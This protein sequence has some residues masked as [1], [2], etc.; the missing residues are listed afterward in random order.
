V[1][2]AIGAALQEAALRS[3]PHGARAPCVCRAA[4]RDAQAEREEA[5][6]RAADPRRAHGRRD[7]KVQTYSGGMKRRLDLALALS[8]LSRGSSSS[9]SRR[10][11]RSQSAARSDG[12]RRL[13]KE[14]WRHGFSDDAVPQEADVLADRVGII[15]TAARRRGNPDA[16]TG[17]N[18]PADGRGDSGD[19]AQLG[20]V[21]AVLERFGEPMPA[22]PGPIRRD[23]ERQGRSHGCPARARR[24]GPARGRLAPA[25]AVARRRLPREDRAQAR[26][27]RARSRV[28]LA[29]Q[30]IG[31]IAWRSSAARCGSPRRDRAAHVSHPAPG[32]QLKRPARGDAPARLPDT[33]VRLLLSPLRVI[34][35]GLFAA[36]RRA[37]TLRATSIPAFQPPALTPLRGTGCLPASS[38]ARWHR[39]SRRRWSTSASDWRSAC[40]SSARAG[41]VVLVLLALTIGAAWGSVG[42]LDRPAHRLGRSGAVAVSDPL[43]LHHHL[44]D[45]PASEP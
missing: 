20:S 35:G 2:A 40:T 32:H 27:R 6:R 28:N 31:L 18:R 30:D 9:T 13:A 45:E 22:S 14:E 17:G 24:R 21:S 1:R 8:P 34:Q 33:L 19:A 26:R 3:V 43:L 29:T 5:E 41:A 42:I 25:R 39:R 15:D 16:L 4:P 10:P 37:P 7:R 23:A 11:P 44:V 12:G 38:A 36:L